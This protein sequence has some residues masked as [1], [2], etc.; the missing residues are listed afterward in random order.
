MLNIYQKRIDTINEAHSIL[1]SEIFYLNDVLIY[2]FG[3]SGSEIIS[4]LSSKL[5]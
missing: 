3:K 1:T 2:I 5:V 4:R